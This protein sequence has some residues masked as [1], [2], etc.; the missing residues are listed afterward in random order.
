MKKH[1]TLDKLSKTR[2]RKL[3]AEAIQQLLTIGLDCGDHTIHYCIINHQGHIEAQGKFATSKAALNKL[4]GELPMTFVVLE[5]GTHSL[6]ISRHLESLG[7][8]V[9]VAN[10]R[11]VALISQ[12]KRK[13]DRVDAEKLARLGRADPQLLSPIQH[14]S[15]Q[16]QL[17]LLVIRSRDQLVESRTALVNSVRGLVKPLGERLPACDADYV[18]TELLADL[19]ESLRPGLRPML[20]AIE[21]IT[22]QIHALNFKIHE[23]AQRYPEIQLITPIDG[24]GELTALTFLLTIEDVTRFNKSREVG[25]YLGLVPGQS[26][27]GDSDPQ[28]HIT[29]QGDPLV[30]KLLVQCA[31]CIMRHNA[32]DSDLRRWGMKKLEEQNAQPNSGSKNRKGK[33]KGKKRILVAIARRLAVLMHHLLATG[34]VYDPLYQAKQQLRQA[35]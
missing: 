1:T 9:C 13:N 3:R 6:W 29:K 25:A 21:A 16:T 35:A 14:R 20:Q 27:S 34:E 18:T 11:N 32:A 24:V 17:D 8:Q 19:P 2:L 7:H 15:E 26:Q 28:Q 33:G 5:A 4:F 22:A 30:R 23:I 10:P 31:H 12:S